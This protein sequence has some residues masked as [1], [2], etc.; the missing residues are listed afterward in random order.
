MRT[1]SL[2]SFPSRLTRLKLANTMPVTITATT[3]AAEM[4]Q[5]QQL[6]TNR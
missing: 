5:K 2:A 3:T 6:Q 1:R 4:L